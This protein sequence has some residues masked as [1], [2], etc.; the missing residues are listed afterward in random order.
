VRLLLMDVDGVLTDGAIH[1]ES[2]PDGRVA[3]LK[4]FHAHDGAGVKM[5][6]SVGVKTGLI[7]G[8]DSPATAQ[9]AR[10]MQMDFV[11][12]NQPEK[13]PAYKEVLRSAGVRDD[14]VAYVGDDLPDL[15]I[16]ARVGLA[17][18]VSNAVQEAK[19]AAHYV[20]AAGGGRGA[21]REVVELIL[22]AQGKW[23]EA[24]RKARA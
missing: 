21:V 23:A 20:C 17:V 10:E 4:V 8:R 6:R 9:R 2:L 16:L 22:K 11:Y 3:E 5:A 12:Q 14:E 1:L 24:V 7:T 13:L 15:P 18:A 19:R